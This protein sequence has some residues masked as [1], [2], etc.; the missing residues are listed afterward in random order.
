MLEILNEEEAKTPFL[1][2]GDEVRITMQGETGR[3]IFGDICLEIA[4][5]S[6]LIELVA[7]LLAQS[8]TA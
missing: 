4:A 6:K 1:Q 3:N 5:V 7:G 8:L 2:F